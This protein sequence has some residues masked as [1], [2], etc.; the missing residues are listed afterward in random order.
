MPVDD[1]FASAEM[2]ALYDSFNAHGEDGGFYLSLAKE[3]CRILDVGCG[4]GLLTLPL[5]QQGHEVTGVDPAFGMLSVAR[6]KDASLQVEWV[7]ADAADFRLEKQFDLAI[8][9]AHVF[10][11]F[12]SD[13][14]TLAMLANIR[15]HLVPN[16]RLVFESRNPVR[17]DW[18]EWTQD[19]T[20]ERCE[21][22]GTGPVEVFYQW[23]KAEGDLVSFDTVFTLPQSGKRLTSKSTLRFPTLAHIETLLKQSGFRTDLVFGWWDRSSFQESTSREII[24]E[25]VAV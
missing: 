4:T 22:A 3:P 7:Q 14:E 20:R 13:E 24:I 18:R 11:V 16:A 17:E 15:R 19:L 10:Q 21:I 1:A 12:L 5:A 6:T 9:T 8:M 25:A 2:A 23:Q